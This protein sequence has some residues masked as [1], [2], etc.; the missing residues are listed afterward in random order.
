MDISNKMLGWLVG[1]RDGKRLRSSWD[2]VNS[3]P[4]GPFKLFP[5][6]RCM[7]LVLLTFI[8]TNPANI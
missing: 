5:P 7:S 2:P 6:L 4:T 3:I 8:I 1:A